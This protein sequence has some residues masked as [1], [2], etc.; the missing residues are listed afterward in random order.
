MGTPTFYQEEDG[1]IRR[2]KLWKSG[3]P[4]TGD[5]IIPSIPLLANALVKTDG[6]EAAKECDFHYPTS[7]C[8]AL[9][10]NMLHRIIYRFP[11]KNADNS[12]SQLKVISAE[13][14]KGNKEQYGEKIKGSIVIIG[15]S[16][17]KSNDF[18]ETPL[19]EMPGSLI[20][21][22]AIHSLQIEGA[23][24]PF[25]LWAVLLILTAIVF[26]IAVVFSQFGSTKGSIISSAIIGSF[27]LIVLYIFPDTLFIFKNGVPF[28]FAIALSIVGI[29]GCIPIGNVDPTNK[30]KQS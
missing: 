15:G 4:D 27:S 16:Y 18:H 17:Q 29:L 5:R 10:S 3:C 20:I 26:L 22:N 11:W 6:C 28:T 25:P 9:S 13:N 1:V 14:L 12:P 30:E 23:N 8:F 19:G 2:F 24:K 21:I 7:D